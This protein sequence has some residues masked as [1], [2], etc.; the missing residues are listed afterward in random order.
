MPRTAPEQSFGHGVFLSAGGIV[1]GVA[2]GAPDGASVGKLVKGVRVDLSI[3]RLVTSTSTTVRLDSCSSTLTLSAES[4]TFVGS[5]VDALFGIS[6]LESA[7]TLKT[8]PKRGMSTISPFE[9][10]A[11]KCFMLEGSTYAVMVTSRITEPVR[12]SSRKSEWETPSISAILLFAAAVSL[13]VHASMDP[14]ITRRSLGGAAGVPGTSSLERDMLGT[15]S[16]SVGVSVGT[17]S[18]GVGEEVV[19]T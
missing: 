12:A 13:G 10:S 11:I 2:E 4:G 5:S 14:S 9:R 19:A 16:I 6:S 7:V 8:G 1:V 15:A 17:G 18:V 3:N